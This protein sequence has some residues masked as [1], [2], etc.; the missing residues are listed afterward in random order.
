M[1]IS[2]RSRLG[3]LA[4]MVACCLSGCQTTR[5]AWYFQREPFGVLLPKECDPTTRACLYLSVLNDS[6]RPLPVST[7]RVYSSPA[8]K[9]PLERGGQ[10]TWSCTRTGGRPALTLHPGELVVVALPHAEPAA[11]MIPMHAELMGVQGESLARVLIGSNQPDSI[12][13][14]WLKCHGG[15]GGATKRPGLTADC[16]RES[17]A[18]DFAD[19]LETRCL[20][21]PFSCRVTRPHG[22]P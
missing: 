6:R 7:I 11:C 14:S 5:G 21:M 16:D 3:L 2:Y 18:G 15:S 17:Q 12:P 1:N 4:L 8:P 13:T 22:S 9:L 19:G 10:E 20:P